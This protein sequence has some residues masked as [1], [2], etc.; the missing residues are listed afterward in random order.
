MN[1]VIAVVVKSIS[2][3]MANKSNLKKLSVGLLIGLT[4][5]PFIQAQQGTV[6][7]KADSMLEVITKNRVYNRPDKI[8]GFRLLLFTGDRVNA[9]KVAN[10]FRRQFPDEPVLLK[11]DEPNFKVVAGLFYSK[12]EADDFR[13]KCS[14]KFPML[15]VINE[16]IDLPPVDAKPRNQ[17]D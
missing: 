7:V 9:E 12:K 1:C 5:A 17:E 13:K 2:I 4:S 3:V 10:D 15:I 14:R 8:T 16:L 11:W 6:T